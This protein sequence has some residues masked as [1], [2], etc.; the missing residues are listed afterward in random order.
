MPTLIPSITNAAGE[1]LGARLDLP[2]EGRPLAYA[3]FAH[4]FTCTK[5]IKAAAHISRSLTK[6]RIAVLR[7]DFTGLGESEGDFAETNFTSN[8]SDLVAVAN[9]LG[10]EFEAPKLLIGHSL[11][12]AAVLQAAQHIPSVVSVVTIAAPCETTHLSHLLADTKA[13][14]EIEGEAR[15]TIG[16]TTF[17]LRKQF[18]DDL[19]RTNMEKTIGSLDRALL[20]LHSPMDR[21]VSIDNAMEIFQHARHPKSFISLDQA[22]HLLSNQED[23]WYAGEVIA[24]WASRYLS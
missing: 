20:I 24:A 21:T 18:F 12:G 6:Q 1:R 13:L 2:L 22:N 9:Y 11:G 15:V 8:V 23:S 5:N 4:C 17:K 3:V 19:D 10:Q 14:A 16:G 7:F